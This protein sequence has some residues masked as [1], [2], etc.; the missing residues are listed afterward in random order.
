MFLQSVAEMLFWVYLFYS[1]LSVQVGIYIPNIA[2]LLLIALAGISVMAWG[3]QRT[4]V[5]PVV[6]FVSLISLS[7][8]LVQ[9]LFFGV[10]P[11]GEEVRAFISWIP[12]TIISAGL[13]IREGFIKR[14]LVAMF[15]LALVFW[16]SVVFVSEGTSMLRAQAEGTSLSNINDYAAWVGFC[17]LGFW[18][19][20]ISLDGGKRSRW[21]FVASALAFTM[22]IQTVSRGSLAALL[23]GLVVSFRNIPRKY[24]VRLLIGLAIL[25]FAALQFSVFIQAANAYD[26]RLYEETGRSLVWSAAFNLIKNNPWIG[27]GVKAVGIYIYSRQRN[28]T[29]HNGILY[30]WFTSGLLPVIPF[31]AM[32]LRSLAFTW[33]NRFA[34][35]ID[36][37]PLLIFV[38]L[39]MLTSNS[40]FMSL[41]SV[42]TI[43]YVFNMRDQT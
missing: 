29:P 17:S 30:L 26:A 37:L 40:Y 2:F 18:L 21:V 5:N 10:G 32:W 15:I 11:G 20:G 35:W 39:E 19:W 25:V 13:V 8:V 43:C 9:Y 34:H 41:W 16:T 28:Y 6:I 27:Y 42:M 7:V 3:R 12:L 38:I 4:L 24:W 31:V 23:I 33:R 36:P 14:W 1:M 22:L